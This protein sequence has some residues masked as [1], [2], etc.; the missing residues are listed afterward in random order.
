MFNEDAP[1][2]KDAPTL[3]TYVANPNHIGCHTLGTSE[4]AFKGTQQIER[5]VL[6]VIDIFKAQPN[7]FDGYISPGWTEANAKPSDVYRNFF[8]YQKGAK[9]NEIAILAPKTRTFLSQKQANPPDAG[10]DKN[11]RFFRKRE[12]DTVVLEQKIMEA[13]QNGIKYFIAVSNMGTT[14][15]GCRQSR[16]IYNSPKNNKLNTDSI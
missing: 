12:I 7:S 8:M 4:K 10:L 2:L 13:K 6:N 15:F 1:S 16:R 9:L 5:V 11:S 3:K 14:M